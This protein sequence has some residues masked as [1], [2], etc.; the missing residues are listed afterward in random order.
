M[1]RK[2]QHRH[3]AHR[4]SNAKKN[5]K[6]TAEAQAEDDA[7]FNDLGRGAYK[8]THGASALVTGAERT[9][10]FDAVFMLLVAAELLPANADRSE[11]PRTED[12]TI[13]QANGVLRLRFSRELRNVDCLYSNAK[14]LLRRTEDLYI[15]E[16]RS[17]RFRRVL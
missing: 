5:R 11:L 3:G 2:R 10:L 13:L 1:T 17:E 12:A 16:L 7:G 8:A 4:H 15:E 14:Q 6:S 9:C